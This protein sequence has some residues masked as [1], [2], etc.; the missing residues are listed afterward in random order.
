MRPGRGGTWCLLARLRTPGGCAGSRVPGTPTPGARCGAPGPPS[1]P[2]PPH[3]ARERRRCP[4]ALRAPAPPGAPAEVWVSGPAER[5][6]CRLG[7]PPRGQEVGHAGPEAD[8]QGF[9]GLPSPARGERGP[10]WGDSRGRCPCGPSGPGRVYTPCV[11]VAGVGAL[12]VPGACVRGGAGR[13]GGCGGTVGGVS[14]FG[15]AVHAPEP[16]PPESAGTRVSSLDVDPTPTFRAARLSRNRVLPSPCG[17]SLCVLWGLAWLL[18]VRVFA[19]WSERKPSAGW[20]GD[21]GEWR[22]WVSSRCAG[23]TKCL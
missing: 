8:E 19:L 21:G 16:D 6:A 20:V 9:A 7:Y 12:K 17:S 1:P 13:G 4:R 23:P 2:C 11:R 15:G 14:L 18:P 5:P 10:G 22:R 3:L